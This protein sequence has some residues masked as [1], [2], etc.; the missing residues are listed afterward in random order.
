[1]LEDLSDVPAVLALA[2]VAVGEGVEGGL[3]GVPDVEAFLQDGLDGA[4]TG[5][6]EVEG[7]LAGGPQSPGAVPVGQA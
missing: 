2:G 3:G 7:T 6:V 4:V 1:M 5:V